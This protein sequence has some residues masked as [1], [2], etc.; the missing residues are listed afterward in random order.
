MDVPEDL[1]ELPLFPLR[2]VLFPGGMLPLKVFEQRYIDL[3][4]DSVR[5]QSGFG[6]CLLIANEGE[7]TGIARI[8]T[9]ATIDDW[10]LRDDGLLGINASGQRRF[11]MHRT[12]ARDNGLLCASVEWLDE[13]SQCVPTDCSVLV[14]LLRQIVEQTEL[15]LPQMSESNMDNATFVANRLA[16]LLPLELEERQQL[17]EIPAADERLRRLFIML[18]ELQERQRQE[19][20]E[21]DADE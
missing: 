15:E 21:D 17:L 5:D 14:T 11:R 13:D 4:R 1:I 10:Y 3:V 16:E 12:W 7:P 6:V 19:E 8:G 18:R 20:G 9:M 2:T